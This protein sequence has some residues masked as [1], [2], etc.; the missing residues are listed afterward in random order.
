MLS[1]QFVRMEVQEEF[2]KKSTGD[3]SLPKVGKEVVSS[4]AR[5]QM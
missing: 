5:F 1:K 4:R 3:D 2:K